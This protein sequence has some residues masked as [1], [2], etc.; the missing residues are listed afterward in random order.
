MLSRRGAGTV[1]RVG[2]IGLAA[3]LVVVVVV[4]LLDGDDGR[5]P[6]PDAS[7]PTSEAQPAIEID[8]GLGELQAAIAAHEALVPDLCEQLPPPLVASVAPAG[9][10]EASVDFIARRCTWPL[11]ADG[12][13]LEVAV[14]TDLDLLD[15]DLRA[16]APGSAAGRS[17]QIVERPLGAQAAWGI[18]ALVRTD[19]GFAL[20]QVHGPD[21]VAVDRASI[22]ALATAAG[23]LLAAG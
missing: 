20:A 22:E 6:D 2:A 15:P 16:P 23:E 5:T 13:V 1:A 17:V 19:A 8:P 4:A 10:V 9:S 14:G 21:A 11:D 12:R 18:A 3:V 7:P